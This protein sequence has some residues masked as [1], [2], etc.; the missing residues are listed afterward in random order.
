MSRPPPYCGHGRCGTLVDACADRRSLRLRP[1]KR[2]VAPPHLGVAEYDL[3][4]LLLSRR[5]T[6]GGLVARGVSRLGRGAGPFVTGPNRE[7]CRRCVG[8]RARQPQPGCLAGGRGRAAGACPYLFLP[9]DLV[10]ENEETLMEGAIG[11]A[12]LEGLLAG[13]SANKSLVLLDTCHAGVVAQHRP[14]ARGLEQETAIG[15]LMKRLRAVQSSQR[16]G[17]SR[18]LWRA[19][20]AMACS[21]TRSSTVTGG[22][23]P[24]G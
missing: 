23:G 6:D 20:G 15:R 3:P 13:V 4:S 8:S 14:W 9:A 17:R 10:Y 2:R 11:Q 22:C 24:R 7:L 12:D 5:Q 18:W 19:S 21:P 1:G 16:A